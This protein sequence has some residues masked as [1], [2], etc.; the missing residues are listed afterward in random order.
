MG[1]ETQSLA[2]YVLAASRRGAGTSSEAGLKYF[3][4]GALASG[5]LLFGAS[6]VYGF[7]G[8]CNFDKIAHALAQEGHAGL[9]IIVGMVFVISGLAFKVA[10]VP[11][12]MWAPDVY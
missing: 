7:A 5:L 8:S 4:L 11:F 2:L 9:G 3:V 10:A 6:L 1:M 12:H